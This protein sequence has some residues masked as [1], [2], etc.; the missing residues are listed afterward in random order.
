G[1]ARV[2]P[3]PE[4]RV[5]VERR[6]VGAPG[7]AVEVR[8]D[9]GPEH[10]GVDP[11]LGAELVD[12]D[13]VERVKHLLPVGGAARPAARGHRGQ[14]VGGL[15]AAVD[16]LA[17]ELLLPPEPLRLVELAQPCLGSIGRRRQL[18]RVR[19]GLGGGR[20]DRRAQ[21]ERQREREGGEVRAGTAE[22]GHRASSSGHERLD[23]GCAAAR[24]RRCGWASCRWRRTKSAWRRWAWAIGQVARPTV[25]SAPGNTCRSKSLPARTRAST[26]CM[27]E[28]G[29]T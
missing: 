15:P 22:W 12:R 10:G 23:G 4:E 2:E 28:A 19:G 21:R 17:G 7:G 8:L 5:A 13:R 16:A 18:A 27:V 6:L 20:E 3:A 26:T 25:C 24:L 29:S 9:R 1:L 11:L 14:P